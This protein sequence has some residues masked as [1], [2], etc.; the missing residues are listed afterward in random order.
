MEQGLRINMPVRTRF[1][2]ATPTQTLVAT[3]VP[4]AQYGSVEVLSDAL[5]NKHMDTQVEIYQHTGSVR[6]VSNAADE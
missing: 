2:V 5:F 3:E 4:V 6:R 1:E